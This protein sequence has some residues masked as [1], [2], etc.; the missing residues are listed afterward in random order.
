MDHIT[1]QPQ[2]QYPVRPQP[3]APARTDP[4]ADA[5]AEIQRIVAQHPELTDFGFGVF[6]ERRLSPAEREAQFRRDRLSMFKQ[7]SILDFLKARDWLQ[8]QGKRQTINR[9]GT[10]YGLKHIAAHDIGYVTNGMFIAAAISAECQIERA[11]PGSPIAF[12]NVAK[13][14][15]RYR[16]NG[17]MV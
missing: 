17:G 1:N 3:I 12:F 7:S 5:I 14:A 4:L 15:W 2:N 9:I 13:A 6:D 8:S 10:S 16:R 11:G